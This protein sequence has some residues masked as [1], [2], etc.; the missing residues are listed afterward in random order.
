MSNRYWD[1]IKKTGNALFSLFVVKQMQRDI[2]EKFLPEPF[3]KEK[4]LIL[5]RA[6]QLEEQP[7]QPRDDLED[8]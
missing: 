3:D 2:E 6:V 8:E 7:F 1:E 4:N 5:D